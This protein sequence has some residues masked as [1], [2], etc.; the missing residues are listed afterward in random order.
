MEQ[1]YFDKDIHIV[2]VD[3]EPRIHEV[4]KDILTNA[5][6]ALRFDGYQDP[7]SFIE[8]LKQGTVTPDLVLLDV[9]FE[10]SGLSGIEIIPFIREDHP[11]LPII[12]L[13]GMEGEDIEESQNYECVYYIP[14]PV[15]PNPLIRMIRFYLGMAQ[16]SGERT[17]ELSQDLA[18]HKKLVGLLQTELADAE[19][20]SW[21][22]EQK[23][24]PEAYTRIVEILQTVLKN[25]TIT[26]SFT[27]DLEDLFHS[28]F[29]LLKKVVDTLIRFDITDTA[30]PGLNLHR[31]HCADHVYSIR[32]S[33]KARI[34]FYQPSHS[35]S[36]SLLRIDPAHDTMSIDKWLKANQDNFEL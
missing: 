23:D 21:D 14:K 2:L 15:S 7:L 32:L 20:A 24:R 13:T 35:S 36:K 5:F 26:P 11:Y 9:H 28:D 4:V 33:K 1:K 34:F 8:F 10:N 12:L 3:D 29:K 30:S 19:I 6:P 27:K 22:Q 25:C 31:H 16:K 17:A 18:E